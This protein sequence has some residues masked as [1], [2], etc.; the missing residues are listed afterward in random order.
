MRFKKYL[1]V[2]LL[3]VALA[4]LA[5]FTVRSAAQE[6]AGQR[7]EYAQASYS[8]RSQSVI[9]AVGSEEDDEMFTNLFED[10]GGMNLS[11]VVIMNVFGEYGWELVQLE[12]RTSENGN[13]ISYTFKR[14]LS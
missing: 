12:V 3:I 7:W 8:I 2:F 5:L 1:I 11:N 14:P 6:Y 13:T 10:I 4:T 9:I